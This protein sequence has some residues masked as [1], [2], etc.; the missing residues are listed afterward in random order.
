MHRAEYMTIHQHTVRVYV[1]KQNPFER[2]L[3]KVMTSSLLILLS[4]VQFDTADK[5]V[6]VI[7]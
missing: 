4:G 5:L 2:V 6:A 1:N 3:N 7:L